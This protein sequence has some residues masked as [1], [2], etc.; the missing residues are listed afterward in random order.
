MPNFTYS[1]DIPFEDNNP[2]EDQPNMKTNTNSNDSIFNVDHF[3]FNNNKGGSHK[4]V[5][6]T[7]EAAPGLGDGDGVLFAALQNGN[8]WPAWQNGVFIDTFMNRAPLHAANGYASLPA[9]LIFQWGAR[10]LDANADTIRD[11]S[12]F[13]F[14][15]PFPTSVYV[16][17]LS[18]AKASSGAE[19]L[20][21]KTGTLST[22]GFTIRTSASAGQLTTLYFFAIGK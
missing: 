1:R 16:V 20:W 6:L 14:T 3:S 12:P 13:L 19:G 17:T 9:G 22:T 15:L 5:T 8:S 11:D 4:Q 10:T 21:V 18:A 2:S 7:N